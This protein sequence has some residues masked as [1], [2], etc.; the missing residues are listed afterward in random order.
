MKTLIKSTFIEKS[1]KI[2][3]NKYDYGQVDYSNNITKVEIICPLHGLFHQTPRSHFAGSGCPTCGKNVT[4]KKKTLTTSDFINKSVKIH[5]NKYNY[6]S[7]EYKKNNQKIKIICPIHGEFQQLPKNHLNG[8]GCPSCAV[9]NVIETLSDF[10]CKAIKRHGGKYDYSLCFYKNS[11]IKIKIIC[12]KHGVFMQTPKKHIM[13]QS[14]PK[15]GGTALLTTDDFFKAAIKIHQNKYD[16][17]LVDYKNN[18][19]KVKIKCH[20][21][22][23]FEQRPNR[24]LRGDGCPKCNC[25]KGEIKI[26]NYLENKNL[27]F[28]EQAK[29]ETCKNK[30]CLPFDFMIKNKSKRYLIEYH[31]EQHYKLINFTKD[32]IRAKKKY[33]QTKLH[34]KIKKNW[35]KVNKVPLLIVNYQDFSVLELKLKFF[36]KEVKG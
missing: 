1:K 28:E 11:N 30:R 9:E 27:N 6:C 34:D 12:P 2:H 23:I 10:L 3:G 33:K 25:S 31:G 13:G 5:G 35:C 14:C 21:H 32:K 20:Q 26:R 36:L 7:V 15:C 4:I 17:S 29:F 24:H 16:Y 18:A 19:T 22:G 8:C